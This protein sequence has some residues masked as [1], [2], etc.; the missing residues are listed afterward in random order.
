MIDAEQAASPQ[1]A[2]A[3]LAPTPAYVPPPAKPISGFSLLWRALWSR[4]R[5][6]L[7]AK[8]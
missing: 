8:A 5:R 4:L 7:A 2:E 1:P 3:E 6:L